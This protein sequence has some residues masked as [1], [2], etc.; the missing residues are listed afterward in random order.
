L[1]NYAV[2][3]NKLVVIVGSW[4]F[5]YNS[6]SGAER[7]SGRLDGGELVDKSVEPGGNGG[8]LVSHVR[9]VG[10]LRALWRKGVQEG[11]G[12]SGVLTWRAG[13]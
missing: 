1:D 6:V 7:L 13:G 9:V 8:V 10:V 11:F 12:W 2:A 5:D 3:V 4:H